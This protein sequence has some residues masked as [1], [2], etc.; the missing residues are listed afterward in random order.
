[1][2]QKDTL[3]KNRVIRLNFLRNIAS[4]HPQIQQRHIGDTG[5]S[6]VDRQRYHE[7]RI[8]KSPAELTM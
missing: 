8:G 4:E 1:M 5:N 2:C 6:S 3:L 7:G